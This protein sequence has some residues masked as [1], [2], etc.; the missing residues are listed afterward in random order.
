MCLFNLDD[1]NNFLN[2]SSSNLKGIRPNQCKNRDK[3]V[4][5]DKT[6]LKKSQHFKRNMDDAN[7]KCFKAR[8][9]KRRSLELVEKELSREHDVCFD[10]IIFC[11]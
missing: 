3:I 11:K 9:N 5:N 8:L 10:C 4:I 1:S 7:L 2:Q 6:L